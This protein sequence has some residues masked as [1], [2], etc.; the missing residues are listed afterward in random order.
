MSKYQKRIIVF[1]FTAT[2]LLAGGVYYLYS[3]QLLPFQKVQVG[4]STPTDQTTEESAPTVGSK[5]S[6]VEPVIEGWEVF[7]TDK[8]GFAFDYPKEWKCFFSRRDDVNSKGYFGEINIR[9]K[10]AILFKIL[11]LDSPAPATEGGPPYTYYEIKDGKY[12]LHHMSEDSK[13]PREIEPVKIIES[14]Q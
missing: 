12:I 11:D 5:C 9:G 6:E 14:I 4:E 1:L 13:P 2:T 7:C 8:V 10:T 3:R